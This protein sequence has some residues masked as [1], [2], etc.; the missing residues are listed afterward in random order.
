MAEVGSSSSTEAFMFSTLLYD[1]VT[2]DATRSWRT[3]SYRTLFNALHHLCTTVEQGL[4]DE[5]RALQSSRRQWGD[6]CG[7]V[8]VRS[9]SSEQPTF[10][11]ASL[12]QQEQRQRRQAAV[13]VINHLFHLASAIL[14]DNG[15]AAAES[16]GARQQ[17]RVEMMARLGRV[18]R[19]ESEREERRLERSGRDDSRVGEEELAACFSSCL[20]LA[21]V[22]AETR[23]EVEES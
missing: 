7:L 23:A 19:L 15:I 4:V 20:S 18:L 11:P 14:G 13:E 10:P 3:D 12:Q 6:L 2:E 5:N 1:F 21:E 22:E 9:G 8:T 17:A 16:E